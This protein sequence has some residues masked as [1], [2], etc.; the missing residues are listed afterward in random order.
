MTVDDAYAA[1]V[2][3]IRST[4]EH[5]GG[6]A[7]KAE[8]FAYATELLR[9][10]L[11]LYADAD[12]TTPRFV[13]FSTPTTH[14]AGPPATDRVQGGVNPDG[15]YD[16]AVLR[17]DRS[18]RISGRRGND[19]YLSLSFSGGQDGEWPDRTVATR[20]DRQLD[21]ADDGSFEV[22]VSPEERPDNWVRMEPDVCSVIVRQYFSQPPSQRQPSTLAIEVLDAPQASVE[23][24]DDAVARRIGAAAAF[25]RSTNEHWPFPPSQLDN[26]FSPPLGYTGAAGALGTTDNTYC[27]GR[28]HLA[29]G[30]RL[31]IETTPIACGYWGLQAWN[32][33]GQS[34]AHTFDD[35][36]HRRQMV[37]HETATM[38]SDGSV[39]IVLADADPGEPNWLDTCGFT[40]G[41]LI[42]RFLYPESKPERPRTEVTS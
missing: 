38:N 16:F 13:P 31:V 42:F 33:W 19:C 40:E 7:D 12:G 22:V 21:F 15:M 18:Y 11:D 3:A 30:E 20:N 23:R 4:G 27:M 25:I 9:V 14:H 28:W 37:N 35:H 39:R 8:G 41:S 24:T 26:A 32:R 34:L 36:N 1:L 17:P 2:D 10:A 29:P 5:V 6:G